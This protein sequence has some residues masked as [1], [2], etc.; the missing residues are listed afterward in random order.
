MVSRNSGRRPVS[1][2]RRCVNSG[3]PDT[4][5]PD[6]CAA[7]R[8]VITSVPC[9]FFLGI[10][11]R[12]QI[13][14]L[15]L[16]PSAGDG[17]V[18]GLVRHRQ[19]MGRR[20]SGRTDGFP[21]LRPPSTTIRFEIEPC[22]VHSGILCALTRAPGRRR[23]RGSVP[24]PPLQL[25]PTSSASPDLWWTTRVC[26]PRPLAARHSFCKTL[27]RRRRFK[28]LGLYLPRRPRQQQPNNHHLWLWP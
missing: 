6:Y 26:L 24:N 15:R 19:A 12:L 11:P 9:R 8:T 27:S 5:P 2:R 4:A 18:L 20:S 17:G 10:S 13:T 21:R 23:P 1:I 22:R 7:T 16:P 3:S 14:S 28:W 25:P